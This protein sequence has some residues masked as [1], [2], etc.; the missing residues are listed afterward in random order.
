MI[1]IPGRSIA[2]VPRLGCCLEAQEPGWHCWELCRALEHRANAY[3][4]DIELRVRSN[5]DAAR[6]AAEGGPVMITDQDKMRGHDT[7]SPSL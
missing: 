1:P 2:G 4:N 7:Y 6:L 5:P 3:H